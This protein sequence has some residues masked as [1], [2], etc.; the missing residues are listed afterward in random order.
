MLFIHF[1]LSIVLTR[2][3]LVSCNLDTCNIQYNICGDMLGTRMTM[4]VDLLL[5]VRTLE[6]DWHVDSSSNQLLIIHS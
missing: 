6:A 2:H 3:V 4:S 5:L 1:C